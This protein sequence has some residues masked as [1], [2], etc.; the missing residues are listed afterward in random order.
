MNSKN[1]ISLLATKQFLLSRGWTATAKGKAFESYSA[2]LQLGLPESFRF[3]LP[4]QQTSADDASVIEKAIQG[5]ATLYDISPSEISVLL[6]GNRQ[7]F[8]QATLGG[9]SVLST[10]LIG[11]NTEDGS[12]SLRT[13]EQFIGEAKRLLLD[14]AAFV[15]TSSPK[16]EARPIEAENFLESCRFLQTARGSF[17]TS[18]EVPDF[19]VQHHGFDRDEVSAKTIANRLFSILKFVNNKV[20]TGQQEILTEEFL[21]E[22]SELISYE[23][24]RDIGAIIKRSDSEEIEFSLKSLDKVS[25]TTTGAL[26]DEKLRDLERFIEFVKENTSA[27]FPVTAQGYIV[28]LRSSDPG[29]DRN[30]VL[31]RRSIDHTQDLALYLTSDQYREAA[32]AHTN[33]RIVH[34]DGMA[35]QLRTKCRMTRINHFQIVQPTA[36]QRA[37]DPDF[38]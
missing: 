12:I 36:N 34:V 6:A 14:S 7:D 30:Y 21:I 31:I 19:I 22:N 29:S 24:L 33:N 35:T 27:E 26:T 8:P 3:I 5:I 17:I 13:F 1:S 23:I 9:T 4:I 16:L 25:R 32:S 37:P 2:P 15:V 20:L 18:F 28:E 11:Q 10:R 38:S